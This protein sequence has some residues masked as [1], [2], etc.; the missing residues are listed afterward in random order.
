VYWFLPVRWLMLDRHDSASRIG[1]VTVPKLFIHG[2][3][4]SIVPVALGRKLFEAAPEPREW[5]EVPGADHNDLPWV[6]GA[7][8]LQAIGA[9][10][11]RNVA[12][13]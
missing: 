5:L 2:D 1:K 8:Y 7:P 11:E 10:L 9:F 6:G 13:R 12:P 4:D 3:S